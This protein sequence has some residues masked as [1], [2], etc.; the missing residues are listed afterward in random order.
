[1]RLTPFM[2]YAMTVAELCHISRV[3]YFRST[4][5]PN[6]N[7]RIFACQYCETAHVFTSTTGKPTKGKNNNVPRVLENVHVSPTGQLVKPAGQ[8]TKN[9]IK[10]NKCLPNN[11]PMKKSLI[12]TQLINYNGLDYSRHPCIIWLKHFYLGLPAVFMH[13]QLPVEEVVGVTKAKNCFGVSQQK[14]RGSFN[15]D[16]IR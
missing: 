14:G 5:T 16:E 3:Q 2:K 9:E 6:D 10:I 13:V 8:L 15:L 1:L 11:L 7:R 12:S 4:K